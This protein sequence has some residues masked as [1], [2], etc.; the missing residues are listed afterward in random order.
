MAD[1]AAEAKALFE[2]LQSLHIYSL[3]PTPLT[4]LHVLTDI[5]REISTTYAKEDPLEYG[6]KYGVIQNK[7][8]KVVP[9]ARYHGFRLM[10]F[11][12][13][14]TG[15]R[16]LPAPVT[17]A[18]NGPVLQARAS[19]PADA[20][21][22]AKS[23]DVSSRPGSRSDDKKDL[24][25]SKVQS[26]SKAQ[27]SQRSNSKSSDKAPAMKR[28]TS[29]IFKSFAKSKPKMK[30]EGTDSSAVESAAESVS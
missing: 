5:G 13:R 7:S 15:R 16:P 17:S 10:G 18:S 25:G 8:V 4:D 30:R 2:D 24:Q 29:D 1:I 12:Q 6:K 3:Q 22:E 14:R 23:K 27:P 9:L 28:D 21:Q 20:K 26:K 19:K 11:V